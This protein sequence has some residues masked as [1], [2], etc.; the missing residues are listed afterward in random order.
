[1]AKVTLV[2]TTIGPLS[3]LS[4]STVIVG[5]LAFAFVLWLAVN[6]RLVTYWNLFVGK[7]AAG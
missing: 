1:V 7:K 2:P 6:N 5:G 4:Q 3:G